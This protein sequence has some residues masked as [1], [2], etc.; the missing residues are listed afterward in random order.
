MTSVIRQHLPPAQAHILAGVLSSA[1]IPAHVW[2]YEAAHIYGEMA[3]GGCSVVIDDEQWEE[4]EAVL[5]STDFAPKE[6]PAEDGTDALAETCPPDG[7]LPG[8]GII[9]YATLRLAP[10]AA[11]VPAALFGL[12][13]LAFHDGSLGEI[14]R[15]IISVYLQ[16]LLALV[17]LLPMF[18]I[19]AGLLLWLIPSY[20]RGEPAIGIIAKVIVLV[21]ILG[22]LLGST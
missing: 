17:L 22:A 19:G 18:A 10:L 13:I 9:L 7:D 15:G 14:L 21:L 5:N 8:I 16:S 6:P 11:L 12:R 4:A 1:G 2:G 3:I 20:R